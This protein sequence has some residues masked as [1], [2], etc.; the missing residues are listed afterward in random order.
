MI[1]ILDKRK[2]MDISKKIEE[3]EEM[4][5][6]YQDEFDPEEKMD[7]KQTIQAEIKQIK[8]QLDEL[9]AQLKK[10]TLASLAEFEEILTY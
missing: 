2:I 1:N 8:S 6:A 4:L 10:T 9:P 7:K 3:L 5:E